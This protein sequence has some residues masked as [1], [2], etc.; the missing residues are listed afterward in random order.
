[1]TTLKTNNVEDKFYNQDIELWYDLYN[2][3]KNKVVIFDDKTKGLNLPKAIIDE[4]VKASVNEF[5]FSIDSENKDLNYISKFISK[6]ESLLITHLCIGGSV[7]LKPYVEE[8]KIGVVVVPATNFKAEF[9]SFGELKSC[10]FKSVIEEGEKVFTLVED[11]TY[12]KN[13]RVYRIDYSLYKTV[14]SSITN[15]SGMGSQVPLSSCSETAK[16]NDFVVIEDVDKHLC[17]VKTL[18]NTIYNNVGQ[19]AYAGAVSL[20]NE[21]YKQFN[22]VLWEYEGGE[23]AIQANAEYFHKV[24]SSNKK[25]NY[26]LPAG[27]KRLYVPMYGAPTEFSMETFA[28]QLRD[29][30]YWVGFNNILRRIEFNCGL[31]YGVLSDANDKE[32]TATEI[33]S[34]KQR[35]YITISTIR[36]ILKELISEMVENVATLSSILNFGL[37]KTD[38]TLDFDIEDGILTTT[39]EQIEEKLLLLTNGIITVD[40]FKDWYFKRVSK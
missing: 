21:A 6:N 9:D 1:M 3:V 5:N 33:I 12:D 2:Q 15:N 35:F 8:K 24:G 25:E 11:H 18:N 16:L 32:M 23:L 34:S 26:E 14:S 20:I 40:E 29:S 13:N 36:D 17:V 19:S 38:Y 10:L 31:S 39:K 4:I 22:R 27:K 30:A 28:P 7:A 37:V